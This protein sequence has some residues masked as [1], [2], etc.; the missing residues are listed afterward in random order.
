MAYPAIG[1]V[2]DL[3]ADWFSAIA[4]WVPSGAMSH[5]GCTSCTDSRVASALGIESWPHDLV[6]VIVAHS[7]TITEVA[8]E[9]TATV[10]EAE[11]LVLRALKARAGDAHDIFDSC[12]AKPL[13]AYL[14]VEV[15]RLIESLRLPA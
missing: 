3:L 11:Q 9:H 12:V 8:R 4:S 15:D 5:H 10:R 1:I 7:R 6:H 14:R 2:E 13:G